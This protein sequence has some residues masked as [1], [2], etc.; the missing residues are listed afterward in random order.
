VAAANYVEA[1]FMQYLSTLA[2]GSQTVYLRMLE[3][4]KEFCLAG[5][6]ALTP[7]ASKS[8][9]LFAHHMRENEKKAASTIWSQMSPIATWLHHVAGINLLLAEKCL[10]RTIQNWEKSD[11][12]KQASTLSEEVL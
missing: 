6:P 8:A 7:T 12:V 5:T 2:Q 10:K 3:R 9:V 1:E 4:Y 11:T